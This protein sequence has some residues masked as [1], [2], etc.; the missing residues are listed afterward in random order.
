MTDEDQ[1]R[2]L[3]ERWAAAVRAL[4]LPG[5]LADHA[6]DIVMF[7]VPP[8]YEGVRG[9]DAYRGSWPQFFDWLASGATFEIESLQVTAGTDVAVA[10][11]LLRCGTPADFDRDPPAAAAAH[12]R[13][14]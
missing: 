12:G 13:P 8:P 5:V 1:I 11:G 3:I 10:H 9:L 2:R 6:A 7:D 4:D 14:P